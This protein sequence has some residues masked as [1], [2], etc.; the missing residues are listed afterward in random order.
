MIVA[1]QKIGAAEIRVWSGG[2]GAPLLYLHGFEQHPG[3]ARFLKRLADGRAV[4]APELPGF[5]ESTG[6]EQFH[7]I[8]DVVLHHRRFLE[9][10]GAGQVDV[11]GHSLGGMFAAE[12]AAL[13]PHVVHRLVLVDPYGLWL[14]DHPAPDPFVMAP[15]TL[16]RVKWHRKQEEPSA[17]SGDTAAAAVVRTGNLAAAGKFMWPVADRG[18]VRRLPFIQAPTLILHGSADGLVP[19]A[20]AEAFARLIPHAQIELIHD[21]GH[22]PMVEAEDAFIAAVS[23]FLR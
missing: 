15:D 20:H 17:F 23:A 22:L 3:P 9:S 1:R 8:I 14:D 19:P 6:F 2:Q 5:G 13:C 21:A 4:R 16:D 12:L 18:L 10:W 11:V 7:D